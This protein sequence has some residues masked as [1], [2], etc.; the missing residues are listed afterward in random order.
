MAVYNL[1]TAQTQLTLA[2]IANAAVGQ[3]MSVVKPAIEAELAKTA[4]ATRGEWSLVWGPVV[5]TVDQNML[6]VAR[7]KATGFLSV[8]LRGT[9]YTVDS[10]WEDVPKSQSPCPYTQGTETAVSSDFLEAVNGMLGVA[11]DISGLT[12]P[13][14]LSAAASA[15][16]GFNL[17][18]TGHSQGA[19]LVQILYAWALQQAP[20][21]SNSGG[22]SIIAYASAPPSPGDPAFAAWI[23]A[24]RASFQIINPLDTIPYWYGRIDQLIPDKVPEALPDTIEGA[25]IRDGTRLWADQARAAGAWQQAETLVRLGS[26]Q[27]PSTIGFVDQAKNQHTHNSYLYLM[28]APQT[29]IGPASLLPAYGSPTG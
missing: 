4:Y 17:F 15:A 6:Y 11:D 28:G 8:V 24:T 20:T 7:Q 2:A 3:K 5:G 14:F 25:L 22:T 13:A 16:H 9:I 26:V 23:A 27:L 1:E 21:W 10:F 29:D 12:L 18:V 19:A